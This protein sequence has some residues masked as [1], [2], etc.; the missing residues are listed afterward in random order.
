M[1]RQKQFAP[2]QVVEESLAGM[3]PRVS[4]FHWPP[5]KSR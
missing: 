1:S 4:S 2:G 5:A 3:S